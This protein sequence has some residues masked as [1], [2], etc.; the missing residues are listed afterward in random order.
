MLRSQCVAYDL[1]AE[2]YPIIRQ[3]YRPQ[4]G[5]G[6]PDYRTNGGLLQ[7]HVVE[8]FCGYVLVDQMEEAAFRLRDGCRP[9]IYSGWAAFIDQRAKGKAYIPPGS[10]NFELA[11]A[12]A[13]AIY[14]VGSRQALAATIGP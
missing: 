7:R 13:I 4:F 11:I 14:G 2:A 6:F 3:C 8:R 1:R 12:V 9:G 10:N 5:T